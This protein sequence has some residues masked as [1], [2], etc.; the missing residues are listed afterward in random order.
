MFKSDDGS[1]LIHSAF[2]AGYAGLCYQLLAF[3]STIYPK[4][5]LL[6][7]RN[8][9]TALH[10][11]IS[12]DWIDLVDLLTCLTHLATRFCLL[13]IILMKHSYVQLPLEAFVLVSVICML[14]H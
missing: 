10:I 3:A 5:L 9:K 8:G 7:D 14:F 13:T 4:Y 11:A 6:M 2:A 1:Y 12:Q